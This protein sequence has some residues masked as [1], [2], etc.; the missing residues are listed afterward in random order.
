MYFL[1]VTVETESQKMIGVD[2]DVDS[3]IS[4]G[5]DFTITASITNKSSSDK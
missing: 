1:I 3:D 4:I 2:I 5:D